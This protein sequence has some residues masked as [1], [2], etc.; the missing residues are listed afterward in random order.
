MGLHFTWLRDVPG[1]YAVLPRVE[2]ALAGLGARPHWGKCFTL[3]GEDLLRVHPR[4]ADLAAL[5]AT[6]DPGRKFSSAF[7]D[8]RLGPVS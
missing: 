4:L 6:V 7:T 1:V 3:T 5:R 8:E 2:A